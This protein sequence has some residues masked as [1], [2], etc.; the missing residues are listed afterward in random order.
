MKAIDHT[1]KMLDWWSGIGI[2]FIDLA[3]RRAN[4]TMIWHHNLSID[5]I[6]LPW[7]KAEN[8]RQADIYIRPAR[9]NSWPVV[10]LDDV[11]QEMAIQI[12]NKYS[13]MLVHTSLSG[14]CHVWITLSIA[15]NETQRHTVQRQLARLT[16]ADLGSVSGEHLGRLAGAKNWKRNGVWVNVLPIPKLKQPPFNPSPHLIHSTAHQNPIKGHRCTVFDN[17]ESTKEW[18]WVCG[19]LKIGINPKTVYQR[20]VARSLPRRGKDANRYARYTVE[21]ALKQIK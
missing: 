14:G 8:V 18:G 11:K 7:I 17:S 10:F 4:G 20:L 19:A 5:T 6:P 16:N 3:V 21:R 2:V 12:A 9:G 15:L 1:L 13:A